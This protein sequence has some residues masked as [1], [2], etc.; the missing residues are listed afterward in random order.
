MSFVF[1][2][3][4]TLFS[5][6]VSTV[7]YF[8]RP[9]YSCWNGKWNEAE[10]VKTW[11]S[12]AAEFRKLIRGSLLTTGLR[13]WSWSV[14]KILVFVI[15][16]LFMTRTLGASA[17]LIYWFTLCSVQSKH[18]DG[19]TCNRKTTCRVQGLK[20]LL[21]INTDSVRCVQCPCFWLVVGLCLFRIA[22][23]TPTREPFNLSS[24]CN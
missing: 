2:R 7:V 17:T 10:T 3:P 14:H 6:F 21:L 11:V 20:F 16:D 8:N 4:V 22:A 23:W 15:Y 12:E 19:F 9:M 1:K 18:P 13:R 5:V 24:T